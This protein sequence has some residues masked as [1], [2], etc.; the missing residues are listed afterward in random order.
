LNEAA[1]AADAARAMLLALC[2]N[3][4]LLTAIFVFV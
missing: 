3:A 2:R 1:G 4:V